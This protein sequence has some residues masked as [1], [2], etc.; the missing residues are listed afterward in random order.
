VHAGAYTIDKTIAFS[1]EDSGA[2]DAPIIY[3][4]AE[5]EEVRLMGGRVLPADV[6]R[7]VTDAAVVARIDEAARPNVLC[8]D[9]RALGITEYGQFPDG[10]ESAPVVP[11]LFFNDKRMTLARWPNEGWAE[12]AEVVESGPAPWRNY[13]SDKPGTFVYPGDRPSRWKSASAVWL[14]GYWCFDWAIESIKVATIDPDK[15]QITLA[16]QHGYGIGS[17]NPGPRRYFAFNLIE[18]LDQPGEYYLDRETG[19]LYFWPPSPPAGQRVVLSTL[20]GPVIALDNVAN[21]TLRGF[22]IETCAGDGIHITGGHNDNVAG[23]MLRNTGLNA[24]VVD[25]GDH[26]KVA[27]CDIYDTG[28]GGIVISGGDRKTLTPCGHEVYNNHIYN[29][30]RRQRTHAYQ[31]HVGG[32]GVHVTHNLL[33]D[34]P[35]QA[36][37]LDG[38]DHVIEFN[39]IHH[40]GMETDDCGSFYMGRNPSDRG[41]VIRYNFWHDIGSTLSHGSCAVYFDDGDGGQTVF[42]NVFYRA[43]GGNF[44]AVFLHGGHDNVV[45]N[46]LFIDCKKAIGHVPWDDALWQKWLDEPLWQGRLLNEVDITKPPYTERYPELAGFMD[47][48]KRPRLNHAANNVVV[49]CGSVADGNWDLRDTLVLNTDPGFLDAEHLNF[50]LP[51]DSLV[52]Q[53]LP[54]FKPIP[55]GQIGLVRDDLRPTG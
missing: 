27:S 26:H 16:K 47:S 39:E 50:A 36:I 28:T 11:E 30:S 42:G 20:T 31:L 1:A 24:V 21:V 34:A 32:V 3:R 12:I 45:D 8:A 29:V 25:G 23:C 2:A 18:E 48:A 44:G 49:N 4:A 19:T 54:G 33:H 13:A 55:F 17:G 14:Q 43:A 6:F 46:N 52:Y 51:P 35:H 40:T 15:H 37:G 22:T 41:T 53:R 5:G 38:N 7:P 9:L 10:F